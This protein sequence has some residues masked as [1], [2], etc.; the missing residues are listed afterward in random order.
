LWVTNGT[1]AGTTLVAATQYAA[2][3]LTAIGNGKAL[4][5]DG[6]VGDTTFAEGGRS[7]LFVTDGTGTSLVSGVHYAHDR[8]PF[9]NW[10]EHEALYP[11]G[12]PIAEMPYPR[13][14]AHRQVPQA[15][16]RQLEARAAELYEEMPAVA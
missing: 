9:D 16:K 10:A 12:H 7:Q 1:A 2:T 11:Q 6:P 5:T 14:K 8:L 3:D 13:A 4:F 15:I